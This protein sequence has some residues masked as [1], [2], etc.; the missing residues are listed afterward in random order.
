MNW[1]IDRVLQAIK[2]DLVLR[3]ALTALGFDVFIGWG[4]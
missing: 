4:W 3:I 2:D 1:H